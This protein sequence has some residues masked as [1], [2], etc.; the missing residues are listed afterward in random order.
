MNKLITE[1]EKTC[2][3]KTVPKLSPVDRANEH[4]VTFLPWGI[5]AVNSEFFARVLFSRIDVQKTYLRRYLQSE[6]T[7]ANSH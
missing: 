7:I 3:R 5:D 4:C 2:F 6:A 1:I